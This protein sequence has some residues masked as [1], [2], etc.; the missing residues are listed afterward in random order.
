MAGRGASGAGSWASRAGPATP[1]ARGRR[2]VEGL[3]RVR[4]ALAIPQPP[5]HRSLLRAAVSPSCGPE[6]HPCMP[7]SRSTAGLM[8]LARTWS[9]APPPHTRAPPAPGG[10][11]LARCARADSRL[12]AV[13]WRPSTS[14]DEP[15]S[16]R[17]KP[18]EKVRPFGRHRPDWPPRPVARGPSICPISAVG[19]R[20]WPRPAACACP[21][22]SHCHGH[23]CPRPWRCARHRI[24][25]RRPLRAGTPRRAGR[26]ST[27]SSRPWSAAAGRAHRRAVA[28]TNW[29]SGPQARRT[30]GAAQAQGGRVTCV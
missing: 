12:P 17:A 4:G 29:V 23:A 5:P 9:P 25:A 13:S 20:P 2:G 26:R 28:R 19:R 10:P 6:V 22:F 16:S 18:V 21:L 14:L 1:A 27:A 15:R 30:R 7:V 24:D 11:M 3:H 8:L